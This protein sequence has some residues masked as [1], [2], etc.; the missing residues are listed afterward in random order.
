MYILFKICA[1]I[2]TCKK[3]VYVMI[4]FLF[5]TI[6]FFVENFVYY[7]EGMILILKQKIF[8]SD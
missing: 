8:Q 5:M 2:F 3:M 1:I 7:R 4:F 6:C